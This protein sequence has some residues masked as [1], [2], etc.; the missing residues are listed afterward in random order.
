MNQT[1]YFSCSSGCF[2]V[3]PALC[4]KATLQVRDSSC[5]SASSVTESN[6]RAVNQ[7]WY[8]S[9][10]SG[11]FCVAPALCNK[12]TLQVRHSSC[13]TALPATG[14]V[15]GSQR[16]CSQPGLVR[17]QVQQ[18]LVLRRASAAQQ[19]YP[20]GDSHFRC[21]STCWQWGLCSAHW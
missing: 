2:C 10:S 6:E 9:C 13:P 19:G 20:T 12:A 14:F 18:R 7:T 8:F 5:H 17:L 11:C 16:S 15:L 3:A 4:N 21:S 1:W